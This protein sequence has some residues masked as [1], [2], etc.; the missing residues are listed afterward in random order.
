MPTRY[1]LVRPGWGSAIFAPRFNAGW[2]IPISQAPTGRLNFEIAVP[3]LAHRVAAAP[4]EIVTRRNFG[5]ISCGANNGL[6]IG[7]RIRKGIGR[8]IDPGILCAAA[9][10]FQATSSARCRGLPM[11]PAQAPAGS[12]RLQYFG[13]VRAVPATASTHVAAQHIACDSPHCPQ[14]CVVPCRCEVYTRI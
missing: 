4:P 7:K 14:A 9:L 3:G 1:A 6:G 12:G 13:P 8:A 2:H 10:R 5:Q 11:R